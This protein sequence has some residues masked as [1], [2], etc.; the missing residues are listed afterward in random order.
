MFFG[1]C[2]ASKNTRKHSKIRPLVQITDA[3]LK[4]FEFSSARF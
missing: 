3:R 2:Y 1:P 4:N